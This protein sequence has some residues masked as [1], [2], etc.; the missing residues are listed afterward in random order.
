MDEL[1]DA[2][3]NRTEQVVVNRTNL[4]GR[5]DVDLFWSSEPLRTGDAGANTVSP[6]DKPVLSVAIQEQLG[7]KLVSRQEPLEVLVI[8]YIERPS[9]N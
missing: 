8:D 7:L 1:A 2:L 4:S 9:D 6:T 3:T 5:F